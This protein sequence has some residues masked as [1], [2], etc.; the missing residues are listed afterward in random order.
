MKILSSFLIVIFLSTSLS[1]QSGFVFPTAK[2]QQ[3]TNVASWIT[4]IFAIGEDTKACFDLPLEQRKHC[5]IMLSIRN[6]GSVGISELIKKVHPVARPCA[7][8]NCGNDSPFSDW[9]SQHAWLGAA[10]LP[11]C[12]QGPKFAFDIP[13]VVLTDMGRHL[14]WR[15][16]WVAIILGSAGGF[17][18]S[19]L[20]RCF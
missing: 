10:T 2:E 7:P 4:L 1:A 14:A 13:L 20:T 5:F 6:G 8:F 9:P 12:H 18:T 19:V 16:D 11:V 15:H 17:A 3:A